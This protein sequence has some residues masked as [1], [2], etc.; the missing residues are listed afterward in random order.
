MMLREVQRIG[1]V[2]VVSV[3]GSIPSF[4]ALI[5]IDLFN[6]WLEMG[7]SRFVFDLTRL[8]HLGSASLGVALQCQKAAEAKGAT[9]RLVVTEPQLK[10]LHIT[11]LDNVFLVHTSLDDA[12]AAYARSSFSQLP[13]TE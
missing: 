1:D 6:E 10:I 4:E 7:E 12:M 13:A 5:E 9:I 2:R 8:T 3:S 11:T